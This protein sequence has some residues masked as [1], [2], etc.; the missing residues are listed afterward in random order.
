M[1]ELIL[2]YPHKGQQIV[3]SQAKRHNW[4]MAGR[5]WRKTTL[6]MAI[7][8]EKACRGRRVIWGAPTYD[9]VRI[10]WDEA[11]KACGDTVI[12]RASEMTAQFPGG[13]KIVYRSLDD[14]DN[15]RG[16]TADDAIVDEGADVQERAW[17]EVVR[18]MLMD[19]G[20]ESWVGGTPKGRNW[21][22]RE[23]VAAQD[24][25]D[26]M[27]W[28]APTV[29]CEITR[30]GL[31]RREHELEN[32]DIPWSEI[33]QLFRTLPERSFRQEVLAEAV[34][35]TG[36][37][38]RNVG[39]CIDEGR[40]LA[41]PAK[42]SFDYVMGVDLARIQD[43][44]V[45]TVLD[46]MGRQVYHER[47]NEIS[48]MRQMAA[49]ERVFKAY[50]CSEIV[51]DGTG[52]GDPITEALSGSGMPVIS[53][54]LTNQTKEQMIDRLALALEEGRIRLMDLPVQRD[55]LLAYQYELTAHG[56][57]RMNAPQGM[58]DDCVIALALAF[59]RCPMIHR[60]AHE[61]K[62]ERLEESDVPMGRSG[63]F[64]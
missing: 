2:P 30:S 29:G 9:Q 11:K 60:L 32:P 50:H 10:G 14:P 15:A 17:Y 6:F 22:W 46:D 54:T 57:V 18:P 23:W 24:S 12:F 53:V 33:Q 44:S 19:T 20:G 35:E 58:H 56:K 28:Q 62:G 31:V 38:F 64:Y 49:I 37:V 41:E 25:P 16:H 40:V 36:G 52:L 39:A 45:I 43:F 5:R 61:Y 4:L 51:V 34:E 26:S 63:L 55:E 1:A 42:E 21:F 8:V 27:S 47:M 48:W 7:A 3:R 13:G 59:S